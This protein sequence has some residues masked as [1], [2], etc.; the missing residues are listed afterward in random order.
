MNK[1]TLACLA[2]IGIIAGGLA[3]GSAIRRYKSR[4]PQKKK[5]VKT[6]E[7]EPKEI[8]AEQMV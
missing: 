3:A 8:L 1:M 5:Q 6:V 7:E 2:S 4:E